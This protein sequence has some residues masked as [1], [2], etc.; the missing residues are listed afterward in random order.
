MRRIAPTYTQKREHLRPLLRYITQRNEP[1]LIRFLAQKG[2]TADTPQGLSDALAYWIGKEAQAGRFHQA[3]K[4]VY[5]QLHP[6]TGAVLSYFGEENSFSGE[7][8][9]SSFAKKPI[10]RIGI[11]VVL[12]LLLMF[13]LT[14]IGGD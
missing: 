13:I 3:M 5:S 8:N 2:L 4:A 1:N 7:E 14:K 12:V 11:A 6:D 10:F 9:K